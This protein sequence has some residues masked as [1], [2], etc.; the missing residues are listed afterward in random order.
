MKNKKHFYRILLFSI[1]ALS[2]AAAILLDFVKLP[3]RS[4][5]MFL[6]ALSLISIFTFL[7]FLT[8]CFIKQMISFLPNLLV[9]VGICGHLIC[10]SLYSL[11]ALEQS[12]VYPLEC[13]LIG[14]G[15]IGATLSAEG[16]LGRIPVKLPLTALALVCTLLDLARSF[17]K[18]PPAPFVTVIN[19]LCVICL[20]LTLAAIFV[21][22]KAPSKTEM[23]T[24]PALCCV[25]AFFTVVTPSEYVYIFSPEYTLAFLTIAAITV[26]GFKEVITVERR[27]IYL[28]ENMQAEIE[29]QTVE[30]QNIIKERENV[31]RF[32]SHD[33]KK[34][35]VTMRKFIAVA[36]E[37]EADIEQIK[38]IDII[39][40]KAAVIEKNLAE[41]A[42]Y[43]KY[44]YVA[45][46]SRVYSV[47]KVLENIYTDL[48]PDCDAN[49]IML[50]AQYIDANA[51][52]KPEL[53]HSVL[54][55]VVINAVEHASC[56]RIR[57][58]AQKR[59]DS[60]AIM[61]SD[62]GVGID[63]ETAKLLF[64]PYEANAESRTSGL[65]L[66]ICKTHMNSMNGNIEYTSD[67]KGLTFIITVPKA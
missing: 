26:Y 6:Y 37:R 60:V 7:L 21:S 28:T 55:N 59:E 23:L 30:L 65:G 41:I 20:L 49:G 56:T 66:Y 42:Q 33:M 25:L 61:V 18:E 54:T 16:R 14:I 57:L 51:Y 58:W 40:Q 3:V 27:N 19:L 32:I 1:L 24:P 53:L 46:Q 2:A 8:I 15:V 39:D 13:C 64:K 62:N 50:E 36:R 67:E 5:P 31:M 44:T 12:A 17:M 10:A 22:A 34:P 43:S 48:K 29:R 35:V 4:E 63:S 11:G 52:V 45:E 38:T 9:A 47:R